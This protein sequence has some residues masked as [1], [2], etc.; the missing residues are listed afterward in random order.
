MGTTIKRKKDTGEQGNGG[1][2]GSTRRGDAEVQVP[3]PG[4]ASPRTS[5][6]SGSQ[7][8]CSSRVG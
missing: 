8:T 1:Q 3:E 6:S 5:T 7:R 2:F 4:T